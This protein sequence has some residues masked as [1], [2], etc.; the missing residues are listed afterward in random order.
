MHVTKQEMELA[1]VYFQGS[2]RPFEACVSKRVTKFL[3]EGSSRAHCCH[4]TDSLFSA[5]QV[6]PSHNPLL[7]FGVSFL[8]PQ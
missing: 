4:S 1:G 3:E 6:L 5:S 7:R 8:L 2:L